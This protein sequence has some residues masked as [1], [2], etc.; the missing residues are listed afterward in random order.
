MMHIHDKF[1]KLFKDALIAKQLLM[2]LLPKEICDLLDWETL[3]ITDSE[4][5]LK[6]KSVRADI[7][8]KISLRG[9]EPI[10]IYLPM[11]H[12]SYSDRD[13]I[14]QVLEQFT[15]ICKKTKSI[16]VPIIILCCEDKTF[17]VPN[18]YLRWVLRDHDLSTPKMQKLIR[19]LPDFGCVVVNLRNIDSEQLWQMGIPAG[20]LAYTMANFW[21]ATDDTVAKIIEKSRELNLEEYRYL[22]DSLIDY[23][24]DT[25]NHYGREDFNRIERQRWPNLPEKELLM[26]EILLGQERIREEGISLGRENLIL[27]MLKSGKM[28]DSV[29]CDVAGLSEEEL[30]QLKRKLKN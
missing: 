26:P 27:E 19:W 4:S 1:F 11:E 25:D 23:Y 16:V 17:T 8:V 7:I 5:L 24:E 21:T 28:T 30:A 18:S 10:V 12:K 13:V 29:I 3:E 22:L 6:H 9:G 14:L 2:M 20:I 15:A